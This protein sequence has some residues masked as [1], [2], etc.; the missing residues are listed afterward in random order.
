MQPDPERLPPVAVWAA[1]SLA[2]YA[3][4]SRT[5]RRAALR[6]LVTAALTRLLLTL[7][8][9]PRLR[10]DESS[11]AAFVVGAALEE[12]RTAPALAA[13]AALLHRTGGQ[14]AAH[15]AFSIAV[16]LGAA[17]ASTR[18]WP[19]PPRRGP[20]APKITLPERLE[21][22]ADGRGLTI[23]ANAASGSDDRDDDHDT[24]RELLPAAAFVEIDP[25]DG[26]ELRKALD[27]A[28]HEGAVAL[29]VVGGDGSVNTA[30]Q[31]A[32]EADAALMVVPAGTFNHLAQAV[33]IASVEEAVAA[34]KAGEALAVDVASI[35]GHVF[36]NTASFG[37]YVELVDTRR[38]LERRIGKW[39]A[40]VVALIRVLR[41]SD[42]IA[43]EIDGEPRVVWMAFIGNCSY[44]PSGFAPT[45]RERLDDGL[46]DLRYV[47]GDQPWARTRL[48]LAV[49]TGR[50]GRTK[51]YRQDRVERVRLRGIEGPLR[52]ARDGETF[53][54]PED[55]VVEKLAR[56]LV[57]F[58][59]D[60]AKR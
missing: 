35:G 58:A 25:D 26:D 59:P 41:R 3:T 13:V 4:E 12:P 60:P 37:S 46:I 5:L 14:T 8:F 9:G 51:V 45:W 10:V 7:P 40:M 16:A 39:P 50:L 48:I 55:V 49:L 29:G 28:V 11:S 57:V 47:S 54:G 2:L 30:A 20:A 43:V 21:P 15:R 32:L 27:R 53:E 19:V 36:L 1:A 56:R 44:H 34:V 42:P 24:L 6:G 18:V 31:I 22:N 17:A 38:R 33:G 23:V 52:L